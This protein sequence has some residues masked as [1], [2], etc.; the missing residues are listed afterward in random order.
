MSGPFVH[1]LAICEAENVGRGTRI[2]A[3][4]YVLQGATIG[5]EADIGSHVFIESDVVVGNRVTVKSGVQL[6]NGVRLMD[7]VFVGPNATFT[8]DL[9][10]RSRV[11][12]GAPTITTVE[13][14]ASIGA[15]ATILPGLTIGEGAMVGAG[16]VVTRSV[17]PGAVVVGN[18]AR[19][20]GYVSAHTGLPVEA[21]SPTRTSSPVADADTPNVRESQ[22]PGVRIHRLPLHR[23]LRGSLVVCEAGSEIP[24]AVNRSFVVFDVPSSETRGEH[25]HRECHQFLVCV[26]GACSLSVT[27]GRVSEDLRLSDPHLGVHVP[28]MVWA[29]QFDHTHDATRLVLASHTYDPDD[30]I[31][32]YQDFLEETGQA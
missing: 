21:R 5:A 30:Y 6:W 15:N 3:H 17:P 9:F 27:N 20:R 26:R 7:D 2:S 23:D 14:G 13:R 10:P 16:A 22:V 12:P 11:V 25:A 29:T 32:T 31:R 1:E 8:N 28:P 18:P 24:F 4:T 19:I